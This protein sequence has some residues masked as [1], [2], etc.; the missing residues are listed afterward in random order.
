MY[1]WFS[2]SLLMVVLK[3][4]TSEYNWCEWHFIPEKKTIWVGNVYICYY[5]ITTQ[6]VMYLIVTD[7]LSCVCDSFFLVIIISWGHL[8]S[9]LFTIY[10]VFPQW[11]H[12][13][14]YR[15]MRLWRNL[16]RSRC[17]NHKV[18]WAAMEIY[19]FQNSVSANSSMSVCYPGLG[20]YVCGC[21]LELVI[22]VRAVTIV[23]IL[24]YSLHSPFRG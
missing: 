1:H 5:G 20:I 7:V 22:C 16:I 6:D 2:P 9:H 23:Q 12:T 13:A 14:I 10:S 24:W 21:H 3:A 8:V 11:I 4:V 15:S 18:I 17:H 19:I